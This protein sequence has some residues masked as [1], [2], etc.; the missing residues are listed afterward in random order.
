MKKIKALDTVTYSSK[1]NIRES[2]KRES[3]CLWDIMS[4]HSK[5]FLNN[6]SVVECVL[7]ISNT[8]DESIDLAVKLAKEM[9]ILIEK[10][11]KFRFFNQ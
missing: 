10:G 5:Q 6:H 11:A 2:K 9:K 7:S 1:I 3:E 8:D 4:D